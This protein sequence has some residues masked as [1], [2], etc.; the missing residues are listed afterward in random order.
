MEPSSQ[1]AAPNV[2]SNYNGTAAAMMTTSPIVEERNIGDTNDFIIHHNSRSHFRSLFRYARALLMLL[3][4]FVLELTSADN[5]SIVSKVLKLALTVSSYVIIYADVTGKLMWAIAYLMDHDYYYLA[6]SCCVVLLLLSGIVLTSYDW[7]WRFS[8]LDTHRR[9]RRVTILDNDEMEDDLSFR[10]WMKRIGHGLFSCLIWSL[11][12]VLSVKVNLWITSQYMVA[13]PNYYP[14]ELRLVNCFEAIPILF[15]AALLIYYAYPSFYHWHYWEGP[16]R[17]TANTA[18][19]ILNPFVSN[20]S[21]DHAISDEGENDGMT[22][23]MQN[24]L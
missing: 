12:C 21:N 20:G 6:I 17:S 8:S 15:G 23:G 24:L 19:T 14:I 22:M 7:M 4:E 5:G 9:R 13:R 3:K 18:S 16:S 1:Q 2:E 10:G 11:Y